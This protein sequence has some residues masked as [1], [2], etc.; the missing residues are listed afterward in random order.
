[1][2]NETQ[3][4][5]QTNHHRVIVITNGNFFARLILE[6]LLIEWRPQIAGVVLI[7]GDYS[8]RTGMNALWHIARKT[9]PPY[10]IFKLVQIIAFRFA[11][12]LYPNVWFE[13][14]PMARDLGI[15]TYRAPRVNS[16]EVYDWIRQKSP[17]LGVSVSCPQRIRKRL[18]SLPSHGF[19]NIHSSLLPRYAGLAPYFWVLAENCVETGVTVHYMT[20]QFD[21][22]N[23]LAQCVLEIPERV[24]AFE[25]FRQ[26][27]MLGQDVL[28]EAVEKTLRGERG[29]PQQLEQRSYYSHPSFRA[30]IALRQNGFALLRWGELRRAVQGTIQR[31][32][33]I[34]QVRID[35]LAR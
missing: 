16:S 11:Q 20:E 23:I 32:S 18:L 27:A 22:G 33:E 25:L 29:T 10:L 35:A 13:V 14:A 19:I 30:Y 31:Q 28:I 15:P 6:R 5:S 3:K 2:P 17:T 4:S 1:M 8:G 9:T 34:K 12:K 24:S 21:E 26:L 7:E